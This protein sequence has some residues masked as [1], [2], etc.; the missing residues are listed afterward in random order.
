M[1]IKTICI[2]ILVIFLLVSTGCIYIYTHKVNICDVKDVTINYKYDE[3]DIRTEMTGDD[4][5]KIKSLL[6]GKIKFSDNPSCGFDETV[7]IVLD[8][9]QTFCLAQDG[10]PI[11]YL[12]EEDTYIKL[13]KSEIEMLH[14][15]LA[16]YGA[17]FP[18][19]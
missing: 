8:C 3:S 6:N 17:F 10:C 12:K 13:S 14:D 16:K 1:K 5:G 11:I 19:V 18:C 15:L 4:I 7:S 9:E 2:C